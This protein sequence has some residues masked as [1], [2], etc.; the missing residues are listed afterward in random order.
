M[1]VIALH[2][3]VMHSQL[4]QRGSSARLLRRVPFVSDFESTMESTMKLETPS[5]GP[6]QICKT[7]HR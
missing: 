1:S 6:L 4:R 2:L 7:L 3:S 5:F